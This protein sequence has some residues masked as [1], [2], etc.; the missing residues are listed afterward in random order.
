MSKSEAAASVEIERKFL[1]AKLPELSGLSHTDVAQGYLTGSDDTVEIRVRKKVA[2]GK[3]SFF[4]TLKSDG[5]LE[6]KE[7]EVAVSRDQF[8]AFW[9]ATAAAQGRKNS[10]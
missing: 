1:V 5:G 9:P 6:R 3:S 4:M 10:L 8:D 2:K 7:I